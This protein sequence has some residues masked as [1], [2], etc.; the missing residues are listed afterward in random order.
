[1]RALYAAP[2]AEEVGG[3]GRDRVYQP[4]DLWNEFKEA[5]PRIRTTNGLS[6]E[7]NAELAGTHAVDRAIHLVL[8]GLGKVKSDGAGSQDHQ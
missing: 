5:G 4:E 7:E 3:D 1:M 8:R 2:P 6:E